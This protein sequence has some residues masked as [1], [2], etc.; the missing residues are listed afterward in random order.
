MLRQVT[1][2][3]FIECVHVQAGYDELLKAASNINYT[4]IITLGHVRKFLSVNHKLELGGV[5]IV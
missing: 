1:I 5:N 3:L 2:S 4:W